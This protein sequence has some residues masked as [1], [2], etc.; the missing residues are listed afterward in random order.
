MICPRCQ[1][2]MADNLSFCTNC[3]NQFGAQAAGSSSM[4]QPAQPPQPDYAPPPQPGYAPPP[5]P[6]YAPPTQSYS[7]P[8]QSYSAPPAQ[9]GYSPQQASQGYSPQQSPPGYSPQGQPGSG[10]PA[11]HHGPPFAFDIKRL[12]RVDQVIGGASLILIITLFLPWFGVFGVTESGF[13]AHGFLFIP[14]LT[15]I[16]L[17]AY[18]VL[19]AGWDNPPIR[20]PVAHAPLLLVGTGLQFLIVLIAFLIKPAYTSWQWGA[21]LALI[22]ALVACAA[23]VVP[24]VQSMQGGSQGN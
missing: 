17:V 1:A 21:Y 4:T 3:G 11:Q 5:Q 13:D 22:A 15:A 18:L 20:L 6:G 24:A 2:T 12:S 7:A 9:P 23:I 14:L 10:P 8:P 19:W 16:L